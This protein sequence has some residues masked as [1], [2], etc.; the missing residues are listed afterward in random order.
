MDGL[1]QKKLFALQDLAYRDFQCKLMP[2][3]PPEQV[4]GV[5]MP[6]LRKLAKEVRGKPETAEFWP[7][8]PTTTTKKTISTV[9]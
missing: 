3:V 8:C 9:C 1:I 5:R 6:A 7:C 2:T 4:I